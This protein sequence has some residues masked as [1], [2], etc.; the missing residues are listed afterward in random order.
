M[1][2]QIVNKKQHSLLI[3]LWFRLVFLL[4]NND[5]GREVEKVAKS[6]VLSCNVPSAAEGI[7]EKSQPIRPVRTK[8]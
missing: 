8:K 7:H 1:S 3:Y 6:D 5:P 4:L 2:V